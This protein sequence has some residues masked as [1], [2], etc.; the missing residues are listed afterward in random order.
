M[1]TTNITRHKYTDNVL[2][3]RG[4]GVAVLTV[5]PADVHLVLSGLLVDGVVKVNSVGVLHSPVPPH[6]RA[7]KD[8][9]AHGNCKRT[10]GDRSEPKS[11]Q[12]L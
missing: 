6:Q 5:L 3:Y 12:T 7:T 8:S 1:A 10:R 9:Q 2:T 11:F 4:V